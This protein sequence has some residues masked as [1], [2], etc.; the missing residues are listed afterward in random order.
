MSWAVAGGD[1]APSEELAVLG[2]LPGTLRMR[3][4]RFSAA[5]PG[6]LAMESC[7]QCGARTTV[8][9]LLA[10]SPLHIHESGH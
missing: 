2:V 4:S 8:P 10:C 1:W 6:H 9:W 7:K 5:R 3:Q